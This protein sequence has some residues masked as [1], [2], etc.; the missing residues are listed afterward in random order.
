MGHSKVKKVLLYTAAAFALFY[1]FSRPVSAAAAVDGV[2][3]G[4][5]TGANQLAEFFNAF[6]A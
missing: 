2:F 1:L 5:I 3:D 6:G 4:I